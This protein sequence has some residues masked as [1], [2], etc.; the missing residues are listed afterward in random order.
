[1]YV[2]LLTDFTSDN[3]ILAIGAVGHGQAFAS[4]W[5]RARALPLS[6]VPEFQRAVGTHT[7]Q[8]CFLSLVESKTLYGASMTLELG[9][10]F[11]GW[12]LGIPDSKRSRASGYQGT[13][14]R[15]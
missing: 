15:E 12:L 1:M 9:R 14:R 2:Q 10:K 13:E 4:Q 5:Y 8:L 3:Q 7:C 11:D 6:Y